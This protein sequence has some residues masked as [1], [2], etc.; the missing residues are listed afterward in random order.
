MGLLTKVMVVL[1]VLL[2]MDILVL[3]VFDIL[4]KLTEISAQ[5][6]G[7]LSKIID[8]PEKGTGMNRWRHF[9]D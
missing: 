5:I 8:E 9:D 6:N 4:N 1:S 7:K 3:S 2:S